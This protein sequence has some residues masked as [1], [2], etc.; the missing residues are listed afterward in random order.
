MFISPAYAQTAGGDGGN[1][2]IQLLPLVLIFVVFYFLI[3]RPQ[4]KKVKEHKAM[5]EALKRGDRVVTSG[6]LIGTIQRVV[7]DREAVLEIADGVRVRI[8]RQM[9]A[10]VMAKTEPVAASANDEKADKAEKKAPS[11]PTYWEILGVPEGAG[12]AEVDAAAEKKAGDAAA[13]EAIDTLKDPVK[14]KLYARLG[15]DEYVATI[16]D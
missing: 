3:I 5:V 16:K 1:F 9:I 15:H 6:G 13:A 11:G 2:F 10:E 4:S 12:Q 8:V 14:R 7:S